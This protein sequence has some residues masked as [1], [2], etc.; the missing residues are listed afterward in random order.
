MAFAL[1][2]HALSCADAPVCRR[3]Q[4]ALAVMDTCGITDVQG[5]RSQEPGV[6]PDVLASMHRRIPET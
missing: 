4:T 6:L 2:N 5:E 3:V 1:L